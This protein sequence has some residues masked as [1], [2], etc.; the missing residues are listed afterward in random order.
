M[1]FF[2]NKNIKIILNYDIIL[3]SGPTPVQLMYQISELL[4]S[5]KNK[6]YE[7]L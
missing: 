7:L 4:L 1:I 3:G 5:Y 6:I 2:F